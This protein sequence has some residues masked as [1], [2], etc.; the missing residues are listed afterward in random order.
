MQPD[1]NRIPAAKLGWGLTL[2]TIGVLAFLDTIDLIEVNDIWRLWPLA[3]IVVGLTGEVDA[4]RVRKS[5]GSFI[6][7]AIGIWQLAATQRFLGLHYGSAM[8]LGIAVV[9]LFLVLHA[10]ID[11]PASKENARD[12]S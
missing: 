4:L 5:D 8:P 1:D 6:V 10:L 11:I 9:G 3:L 7:L 2:L 12:R